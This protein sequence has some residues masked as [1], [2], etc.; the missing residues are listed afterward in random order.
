MKIRASAC[1]CSNRFWIRRI[2]WIVC[3]RSSDPSPTRLRGGEP[4]ELGNLLPILF[5][6]WI[7]VQPGRVPGR[8]RALASAPAT[9]TRARRA[10]SWRQGIARVADQFRNRRGVPGLV[11]RRW[12]LAQPLF[13]HLGAAGAGPGFC[14][15]LDWRR[16][17]VLVFV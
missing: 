1:C 5:L 17:S 11:W 4:N 10:Y 9:R 13:E 14:E 2:W 3:F 15:W 6:C 8:V 12:I 16:G 7:L